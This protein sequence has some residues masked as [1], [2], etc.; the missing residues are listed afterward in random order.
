[1]KFIQLTDLEDNIMW[2]QPHWVTKVKRPR[3]GDYNTFAKAVVVM[4]NSEQ[5]VR[6][7]P[8]RVVKLIEE[9]NG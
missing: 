4:G 9:A 8:E 3:P 1:M 2:V 6:E 5:A 7:T